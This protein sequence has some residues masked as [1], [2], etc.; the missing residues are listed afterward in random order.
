MAKKRKALKM[1]RNKKT[2][3]KFRTRWGDLRIYCGGSLT[4][5]YIEDQHRLNRTIAAGHW[6]AA[7]VR[8]K[9]PHVQWLAKNILQ[10]ATYSSSFCTHRNNS[11]SCS[12]SIKRKGEFKS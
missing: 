7:V 12:D 11:F 8:C 9:R 10:Q 1:K 5:H 2:R 3:G 4:R 6:P